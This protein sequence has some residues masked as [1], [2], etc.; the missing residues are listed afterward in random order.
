M[1]KSKGFTL[2]ELIIVI[3]IVAILS[4]VAVP[5]YRGYTQRAMASEGKTLLGSISSAQKVYFA[6]FG[7][8]YSASGP[9]DSVL[10]VD[11]RS[12]KYFVNWSVT[13]SATGFTASTTGQAGTGVAGQTVMLDVTT[14]GEPSWSGSIL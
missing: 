13:G 7:T 1:K 6:E 12:N 8:F 3:V 11:S 9:V 14:T 10:D 4:I 2:V 5:M